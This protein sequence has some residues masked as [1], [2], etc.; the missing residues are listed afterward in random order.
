MKKK[1][2]LIF[3]AMVLVVPLAG[4]AACEAEEAP[5]DVS[6]FEERIDKL[7]GSTILSVKR[8]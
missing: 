2:L 5:T 4:F 8:V 6:E 7:E 1:V 3:L